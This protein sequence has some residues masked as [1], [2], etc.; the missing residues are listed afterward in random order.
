MY[1]INFIGT[2]LPQE[3]ENK[4]ILIQGRLHLNRAVHSDLVAVELLPEEEWSLPSDLILD[5]E[6]QPGADTTE[7]DESSMTRGIKRKRDNARPTGPHLIGYYYT[8]VCPEF[9]QEN[10]FS[11]MKYLDLLYLNILLQ[12]ENRSNHIYLFIV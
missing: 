12:D 7:G 9:D 5:V 6:M 11:A 3:E 10:I 1:C 8:I 4:E 2:V